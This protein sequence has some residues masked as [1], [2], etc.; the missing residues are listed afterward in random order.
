[1]I[2]SH[3]TRILIKIKI[4]VLPFIS[5][6]LD[7]PSK[8]YSTTTWFSTSSFRLGFKIFICLACSSSQFFLILLLPFFH[9]YSL[10]PIH[11]RP[12]YI[13]NQ[14]R[15][16]MLLT[17]MLLSHIPNKLCQLVLFNFQIIVFV[18]RPCLISPSHR[19]LFLFPQVS[20][21]I[22]PLH[23]LVSILWVHYINLNYWI[24]IKL[25]YK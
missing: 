9:V 5:I 18:S 11:E 15:K 4:L 20:G 17:F 6:F 23:R 2:R 1:M 19:P 8:L 7:V 3:F 21:R 12:K 24:N 10:F 14:D 25:K 16:K 13:S 22:I